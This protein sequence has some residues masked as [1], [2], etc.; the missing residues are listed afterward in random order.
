MFE[1]EVWSSNVKLAYLQST[2][3]LVR[4]VFIKNPAPEFELL[5]HECF[6]LLRP[7]YGLI[8]AGDLLHKTLHKHLTEDIGLEATKADP[9]LYFSFREGKL[10]GINGSNVDDL[11]RAGGNDFRNICNKTHE[12]FETSGDETAPLTFAGFN[13]EPKRDVPF[14]IDQSST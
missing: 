2:E 9:S 6:E 1:F 7:L 11:L 13:I 4:R 3:P 8:D 10:I 12:R 5:P 14:T